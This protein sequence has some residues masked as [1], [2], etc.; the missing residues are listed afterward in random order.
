MCIEGDI[1]L[2]NQLRWGQ[3]NLFFMLEF[4]SQAKTRE[5]ATDRDKEAGRS[6]SL[7]E[8]LDVF[9]ACRK[10]KRKIEHRSILRKALSWET[11][12]LQFAF[13]L[14][15]SWMLLEMMTS[16]L[17]LSALSFSSVQI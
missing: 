15:I 16:H 12:K 2:H 8:R 17:Y 1:P 4:C 14:L 10:H 5:E 11:E 13:S 3:G 6:L 9:T 7:V